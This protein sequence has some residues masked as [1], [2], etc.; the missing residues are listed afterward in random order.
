MGVV[1]KAEDENLKRTVA[2]KILPPERLG[3][4]ESRLGEFVASGFRSLGLA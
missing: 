2:L 1:Y 3:D 4:E